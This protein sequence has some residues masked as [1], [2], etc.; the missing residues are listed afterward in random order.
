MTCKKS[1]ERKK[2]VYSEKVNNIGRSNPR[3]I[4]RHL[5]LLGVLDWLCRPEVNVIKLFLAVFPG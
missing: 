3:S 4:T 5:T 2:N 1:L